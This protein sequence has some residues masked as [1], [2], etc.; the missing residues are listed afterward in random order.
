M[1]RS[2]R[3]PPASSGIVALIGCPFRG[4]HL[5]NGLAVVADGAVAGVHRKVLL[6]NYGVFDERRYFEPGPRGELIEVN[7]IRIGL[8][9]CEDIWF[10]GPPTTTEAE[11]GASLIVNASASP[12][13]RG[14]GIQRESEVVS[15]RA[16]ESS[17]AVALCN[18]VGGQDELVFDGHSV[19][20]DAGGETIARARQFEPE[21]L[22]CD[23]ELPAAPE[24]RGER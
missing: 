3:S 9:V 24:R 2:T 22:V 11:A 21:L 14:R 1:R 15:A 19:V 10:P 20:V 5:Y 17:V 4:D 7:G 23:L 8:T 16:R 18:L 6:P 13:H 12:Y